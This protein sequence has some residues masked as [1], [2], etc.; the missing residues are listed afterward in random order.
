MSLLSS[1]SGLP[2]GRA[3]LLTAAL[4]AALAACHRPKDETAAPAAPGAEAPSTA[5]EAAAPMAYRSNTP[6]ASVKLDLPVAVR[7]QP[8]LHARLYAEEVRKLHQFSEGAQADRTEAGDDA[9]IP[10]YEKDIAITLAAETGKL[11]SLKRVDYDNSGGAHPNTLSSGLLWDKALKR[12]VMAA[13]LFRKG[14]DMTILDQALCSAINAAK[15]ARVPDSAV[16]ALDGRSGGCP[17]ALATAFI[18]T[19]GSV[20]GRAGGLTFLIGPYEVGA[21]AEGPYE[22]AIP[23]VVFRSLLTAAY[24]DEFG[25]DLVKAGDVTPNLT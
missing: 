4:A 6:Y 12:E 8:D 24:A 19:P 14:A 11:L 18:L 17:R 23:A 5:A 22:L 3:L 10:A 13:D 16:L 2:R 1:S 7:A 20:P 15:R 25:G 9:A 21:Y